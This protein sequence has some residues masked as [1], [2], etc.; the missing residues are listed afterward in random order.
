MSASGFRSAAL[1]A[2]LAATAA[3]VVAS[4]ASAT[5]APVDRALPPGATFYAPGFETA[6]KQQWAKLVA[7]G[8]RADADLLAAMETTPRAVWFTGGSPNDVRVGVQKTVHRAEAKNELPVLV[9]YDV[10]GRDCQQ[11]SAGGAANTAE[12]LAWIDGFASGIGD[13][14]AIVILEPDGLG[15]LPGANCGGGPDNAS[16]PFTDEER[17]GELH[18]AVTRL[19]R[20]PGVRVYLDATHPAWMAVGDIAQRLVDAGVADAQGFFLNVSNYQYTANAE[21]YGTWIAQCIALGAYGGACPNQYWDGGPA[22]GWAGAALDPYQVWGD[23]PYGG[24]PAELTS[25]T[26]GI[27]SRY[28]QLLGSTVPTTH[29]V[30]DTSRNGAGPWS[31]AAA[32]YPDAGTAQDWCNPPGRG[33]GPRPQAHPDPANPLLDAYL[34][35]KVPGESDGSCTRGAAGAADPEWGLVDPPAGAWFPEQALELARN[36]QPPLG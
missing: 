9:A 19:E 13:S 14:R 32:G 35:V 15:L 30:V 23:R 22:T 36:A 2:A 16:Y 10:P 18:A 29:F 25:N 8:R 12:Y 34:W 27:D 28:A 3:V 24:D 26:A 5:Q 20:Q 31:W 33:V 6:A 7:S 21:L 17:Y 4:S 11:Y 1:A